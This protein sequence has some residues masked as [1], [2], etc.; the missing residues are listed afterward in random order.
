LPDRIAR[1]HGLVCDAR[2]GHRIGEPIRHQRSIESAAF[3]RDGSEIVTGSWDNTA[4]V[5]NTLTGQPIS[6]AVSTFQ[7]RGFCAFSP[8][9]KQIVTV[10]TN[11][12]VWIWD[13][14]SGNRKTHR[15]LVFE[16]A[17]PRLP[18]FTDDG[19]QVLV[20][21]MEFF[22]VQTHELRR[23]IAEGSTW[24]NLSAEFSPDQ[25]WLLT[26]SQDFTAR[27]W[28]WQTGRPESLPMRH[29]NYVIYAGWS[30]DGQ[31]IVTASRDNTARLWD[32]N[33]HPKSEPMR[34]ETQSGT[35]RSIQWN[36][37]D[38]SAVEHQCVDLG[39]A[40]ATERSSQL[41]PRWR[42]ALVA[43]QSG[44]PAAAD[45]F[46]RFYRAALGHRFGARAIRSA[47][48]PGLGGVRGVESQ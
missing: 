46:A 48:A 31:S 39:N 21:N 37:R 25:R 27:V 7:R 43:V 34:H 38:D 26:G 4:R 11:G 36:T 10:T 23:N 32:H 17:G 5:W 1:R 20:A 28:D 41:R 16:E 45:D 12:V 40:H 9:A 29:D 35:R 30:P 22:D 2:D 15:S 18:S 47:P 14:P 42:P 3:S 33:G 24:Y 44:W 13:V 8:D 6:S 19:S